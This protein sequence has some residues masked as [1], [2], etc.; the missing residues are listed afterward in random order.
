MNETMDAVKKYFAETALALL[1]GG[2]QVKQHPKGHLEVM[3]DGQPL[4]EVN[5]IGGIAY[6]PGNIAAPEREEAKNK[7]F[8]IVMTTADYMRKMEKAPTLEVDTLGERYKMLADVGGSVLA[9]S[10]GSYG[11][12]FVTWDWDHDGEG[13]CQ[14]H[15]FGGDY[16]GAKQDFAIRSGLVPKDRLFS[17]EQLATIYRCCTDVLE[18]G[19]CSTFEQEKSIEDIRE[20]IKYG[21]PDV[22]E[23]LTPQEQNTAGPSPLDQTM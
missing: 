13:V 7:V 16:Q 23:Q 22:V 6:M 8:E 18:G 15:Y 9:G 20:Q 12:E 21:M 3:M 17:D 4:C 19:L 1:R 10:Y 14:G 5:K 2:F 11:V